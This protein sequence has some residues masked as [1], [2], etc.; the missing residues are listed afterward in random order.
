MKKIYF[1]IFFIFW[2]CNEIKN[3]QPE[4]LM[5]EEQMVDFLF[6]INIINSSRAFR[7][8]SERNYYNIKDSFL[9]KKHNIDSTVFSKSNLYYSSNPKKYLSIYE[10]L[11]KK[12]KKIKDSLSIELETKTK[13]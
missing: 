10:K 4:N 3:D 6:D 7:N 11:E 2:S 1:I 9:F 12:L 5:T 13:R 8:R